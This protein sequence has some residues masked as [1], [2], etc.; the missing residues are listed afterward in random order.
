MDG[1]CWLHCMEMRL[2]ELCVTLLATG[3]TIHA[4]KSAEPT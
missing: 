3:L 4:A 2:H 1:F